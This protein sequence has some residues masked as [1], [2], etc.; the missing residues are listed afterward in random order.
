MEKFFDT[1]LRRAVILTLIILSAF[2]LHKM[3][4]SVFRQS[5]PLEK[6]IKKVAS[7]NQITFRGQGKVQAVADIAEF[8]IKV[9]E[10]DLEVLGAQSKM[11]E[12][13]NKVIDLFVTN[14]VE[15]KDIKTTNYSINP[16]YSFKQNQCTN[17]ICEIR[18]RIISGYEAQESV[19]VKLRDI[20]RSGDM[21]TKI[22]QLEIFEVRGPYFK[23]GDV[24]HIRNQARK[25]AI[26]DAKSKAKIIAQDLGIKLGKITSFQE[27]LPH[28]SFRSEMAMS[29]RADFAPA[30]KIEP[31]Q[32]EIM[33]HVFITYEIK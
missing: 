1:N 3:A 33:S 20:S 8:V 13:I 2:L 18:Q 7:P 29:A 27:E 19:S 11:T 12:K 24:D 30:P 22:A 6:G 17:G 4:E 10:K 5:Q 9:R 26:I 16:T 14:G 21:L 15:K 31:G 25:E 23:V 28:R 32:S